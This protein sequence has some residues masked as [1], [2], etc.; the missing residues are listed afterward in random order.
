MSGQENR[1]WSFLD[2]PKHLAAELL[3]SHNMLTYP[4]PV[5]SIAEAEGATVIYEPLAADGVLL[6]ENDGYLMKVNLAASPTRRRYSVAHELGHMICDKMTGTHP[7]VRYRAASASFGIRAEERFCQQFASYLLMPDD[8]IADFN[9][10]EKVRIPE[11]RLRARKLNVSAHAFLWRVLEQLP[12]EGGAIC[13]RVMGKPNNRAD[14]KLRLDWDVFPKTP[15][16]FLARYDAVPDSSPIRQVLG[17][18]HQRL[19]RDV[20][21]DFG[22]LRGHRNLLI[23]AFGQTVLTVVLPPEV[24]PDIFKCALQVEAEGL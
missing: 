15:K 17:H 21:L 2:R 4:V 5:A 3:R 7:A 8:S 20:K 23:Q 16:S 18:P 12:Y 13:F 24:D 9:A 14:I 22:S 1:D 10:W 19:C 6:R 11:L